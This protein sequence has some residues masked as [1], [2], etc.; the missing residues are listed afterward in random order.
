MTIL[1]FSFWK[2]GGPHICDCTQVA[3]TEVLMHCSKSEPTVDPLAA[4]NCVIHTYYIQPIR[5]TDTTWDNST[6][7]LLIT[8]TPKIHFILCFRIT[9]VS[10]MGMGR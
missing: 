7:G 8:H 3:L 6:V 5:Y 2:D 9:N 1:W 4:E 10:Q